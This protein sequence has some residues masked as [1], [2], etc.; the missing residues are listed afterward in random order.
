[1][2]V[3]MYSYI[4]T[5]IYLFTLANRQQLKSILA[6]PI[7]PS[8]PIQTKNLPRHH[9]R[10][11]SVK[12][13]NQGQGVF[14]HT[15]PCCPDVFKFIIQTRPSYSDNAETMVSSFFDPSLNSAMS[16]LP[17]SSLS[18]MRKILRTRFSGVSSSSG[19]LTMLPT[20]FFGSDYCG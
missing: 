9:R 1:M 19:S 2:I 5:R 8:H 20:Y 11:K 7:P 10:E 13:E 17:F 12:R 18:I 14:L 3:A 6:D 15:C 16:R 4:L